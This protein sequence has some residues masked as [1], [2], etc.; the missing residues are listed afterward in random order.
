MGV[1]WAASKQC[2]FICNDAALDEP[3]KSK[4]VK[5]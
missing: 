4:A 5:S 2:P 3:E 1:F